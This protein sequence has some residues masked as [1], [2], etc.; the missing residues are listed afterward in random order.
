MLHCYRAV[1]GVLKSLLPKTSST[2]SKGKYSEFHIWIPNIISFYPCG[3]L[4]PGTVSVLLSVV[5]LTLSGLISMVTLSCRLGMFLKLIKRL[6]Q[7]LILNTNFIIQVKGKKDFDQKYSLGC[8]KLKEIFC[9]FL[10]GG[11]G[12]DSFCTFY[13]IYLDFSSEHCPDEL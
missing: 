4:G 13:V 10:T 2:G 12:I 11:G 3:P 5:L 9:I 1:L 7:V 8:Q 6:R